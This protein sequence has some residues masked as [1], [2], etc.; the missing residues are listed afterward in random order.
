MTLTAEVLERCL[1]NSAKKSKGTVNQSGR[2]TRT[3][4][5]KQLLVDLGI[6]KEYSTYA[7]QVLPKD[8][9]WMCDV[10][11]WDS[12]RDGDQLLRSIPLAAECEWGNEEAIWHD[13]QKLLIIRASV[14]VMIFRAK[15]R[16][17]ASKLQK[18]LERQIRCFVSSQ[19]GDR[20]L[21]A[22]YVDSEE[23]PFAVK[24]YVFRN[25]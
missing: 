9:E 19:E 1:N 4:M 25:P 18:K 16:C 5:V 22:S 2:Q 20:Y 14:R 12:Y 24:E 6:K 17:E 13:F 8:S 23:S 7:S 11:W 15:S 21:F 10:V 3:I